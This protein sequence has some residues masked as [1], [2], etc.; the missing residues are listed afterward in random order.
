MNNSKLAVEYSTL[1]ETKADHTPVFREKEEGLIEIISAIQGISKS[2]EWSTLKEKVFDNLTKNLLKDIQDEARK[3][4]PDGLKLNRLAGQL[5]WAEKFSDLK[6]F[7]NGYRLE[8]T[9]VRIQLY[10]NNS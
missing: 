10:G 3:T 1:S 7:E 6:K 2:K 4:T 8:L 5:E 9:N